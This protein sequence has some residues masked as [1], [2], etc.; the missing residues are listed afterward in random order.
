VTTWPL[1]RRAA[2]LPPD[3][4]LHEGIP[5]WLDRPLTDWITTCRKIV[6]ETASDPQ[7]AELRTR[8]W[9]DQIFM[10][11]RLPT[12]S[13]TKRPDVE[14]LDII[15]AMLVVT[16]D[17]P[18]EFGHTIGETEGWSEF[19]NHLD[20]ALA[21]SGSAWR[22]HQFGQYLERRVDATVTSAAQHTISAAGGTAGEH[23]AAAWAA[24]YG[25]QPD[26][27]KAYDE[28]VLAVE[29]RACPLVCPTNPRRTLGTVIRDLRNQTSQWELAI[30]DSTGQP[31]AP[32]RMIDMLALLWEGQSR[33]A[34]SPNSRRQTP[35]ESEAA[36]HLAITLVQWLS[37]GAL[38][39]KTTP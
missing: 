19:V 15:D 22:V 12:G 36:L 21:D 5:P 23:L 37:A 10:R 11:T 34:G 33:H 25:R 39:R 26:P 14:R 27:D 20:T 28:A 24:A 18:G 4:T 1:S 6:A 2:G 7:Y 17:L 8:N 16:P 32:D 30:G 31:A 3:N 13:L 38:S 9:E 35:A 29:D